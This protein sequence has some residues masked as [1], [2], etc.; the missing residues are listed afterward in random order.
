[1]EEVHVK[2]EL[3]LREIQLESLAILKNIDSVCK[4]EGIRY[5]IMFGTL[6]G[7][8]RH[9]GFIPWDDDLDIAMPRADYERFM[10][11]FEAGCPELSGYVPLAPEFGNDQPFLITR[12]SNPQFKMVG[13]YGDALDDLGTFVDIYPLD[14]LGQDMSLALEHKTRAY[15]LVI[16]YLRSGNFEYNNRNNGPLKRLAKGCLSA[17]LGSP[18]KYQ[19]RL[20]SLCAEYDYKNSSLVTNLQWTMTPDESIYERKWFDETDYMPFEDTMAPVPKGYDSLLRVDYGD[21]MKLPPENERVGH[22]YY[23]IIKRS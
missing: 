19:K 17:A 13:E 1:M 11:F 3:S 22:H 8:V 23:S 6:I 4:R 18:S 2:G 12:I 16:D 15:K 7:A 9:K 10:A 21:Y 5:W 14:G 20:W